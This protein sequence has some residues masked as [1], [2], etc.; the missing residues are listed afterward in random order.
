M[1]RSSRMDT[2]IPDVPE[3]VAGRSRWPGRLLW[4]VVGSV[5]VFVAMALILK[6]EFYNGQAVFVVPLWQYYLM[7]IR[8]AWQ[9]S[10]NLGPTSGNAAAAI[11]LAFEHV[12]LSLAGGLLLMGM[13]WTIGRLRR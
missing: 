9:S 7:E 10:G 3:A 1:K 2:I 11:T 8:L 6:H 4:F 13:A 5:A 12:L